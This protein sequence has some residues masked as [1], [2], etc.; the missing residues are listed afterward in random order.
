MSV[1]AAD[2][3]WVPGIEVAAAGQLE[4]LVLSQL[5][6]VIG[7]PQT[8]SNSVCQVLLQC[9]WVRVA[10]KATCGS[11]QHTAGGSPGCTTGATHPHPPTYTPTYVPTHPLTHT[12]ICTYTLTHRTHTHPPT[13]PPTIH[14]V[15]VSCSGRVGEYDLHAAVGRVVGT[16]ALPPIVVAHIVCVRLL[17]LPGERHVVQ[18]GLPQQPLTKDPPHI[19]CQRPSSL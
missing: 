7:H 1:C 12:H 13:N 16:L 11:G 15:V 4:V 17:K 19:P 14:T 8:Q 5:D 9:L 18:E 10:E 3:S 6:N 2:L